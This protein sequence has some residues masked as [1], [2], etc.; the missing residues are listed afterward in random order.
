MN[1]TISPI[2]LP[3]SSVSILF[4]R[5]SLSLHFH[6]FLLF[7]SNPF[8][9][10]PLFVSNL[11]YIP[12]YNSTSFLSFLLLFLSSSISWTSSCFPSYTHLPRPSFS[13]PTKHCLFRPSF[14]RVSVLSGSWLFVYHRVCLYNSQAFPLSFTHFYSRSSSSCPLSLSPSMQ[15]STPT[16][17]LY[18]SARY[19]QFSIVPPT[20]VPYP[21]PH[22]PPVLSFSSF[23]SHRSPPPLLSSFASTLFIRVLTLY[24]H[25]YYS[26]VLYLPYRLYSAQCLPFSLIYCPFFVILPT[27]PSPTRHHSSSPL[28]ISPIPPSNRLLLV[29]QFSSLFHAYPSRS[30]PDSVS[31]PALHTLWSSC[32]LSSLF[33]SPCFLLRFFFNFLLLLTLRF[34]LDLSLP[35][36]LMFYLFY[37]FR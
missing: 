35:C 34:G 31:T 7:P 23:L 33:S 18:P 27:R 20:A 36:N 22:L 32:C 4:V 25:H 24:P 37:L 3:N 26:S 9:H 14:L 19:T 10:T 29:Y 16:F 30:T 13:H 21:L 28:F 12:F 5:F 1:K 11:F 6:F 2:R 8:A 15:Q 17:P